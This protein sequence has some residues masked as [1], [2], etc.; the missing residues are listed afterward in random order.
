MQFLTHC[1]PDFVPG[2]RVVAVMYWFG[3]LQEAGYFWDRWEPNFLQFLILK[4]SP[5][6]T[7]TLPKI[8]QGKRNFVLKF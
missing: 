7:V 5:G 3:L 2:N 4:Y 8:G 6:D 1:P